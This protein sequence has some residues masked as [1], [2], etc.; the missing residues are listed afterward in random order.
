MSDKLKTLS[1]AQKKVIVGIACY[2]EAQ[3]KGGRFRSDDP[4]MDI[5]VKECFD[6]SW[7]GNWDSNY[8]HQYLGQAATYAAHNE[9]ECLRIASELDNE[10][11]FAFKSMMIDIIGDNAMMMLHAA[12]IY[13]E[14]GMPVFT[15]PEEKEVPREERNTQEDDGTYVLEDCYRRLADVGAVR[16]ENDKVFTMV[17]E[18]RGTR[19]SVGA[20]YDYWLNHGI[21]PV[22]GLVG[23][24]NPRQSVDTPEGRLYYLVCTGNLV[25]PVLEWGLEKIDEWEYRDKVQN[26]RMLSWDRSGELCRELRAR[27]KPSAPQGIENK[28]NAPQDD[29]QVVRWTAT[30]QQ[31]IEGG[32]VFPSNYIERFIKLTYSKRGS[33]LELEVVGVMKPRTAKIKSDDGRVLTYVDTMRPFAYYEVET[34]PEHNSIVR[35]S[36]F[37]KNENFED[38]E[39]RYTVDRH[40][41]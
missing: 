11:K 39:Y 18:D 20:N 23:Y 1:A 28:V 40:N 25:I 17:D 4:E 19:D 14:I 27:K 31:R 41:D 13:K 15:K 10:A 26:D 24:V 9:K 38:L 36:I 35:V 30:V 29:R 6:E 34:E 16:G 21:C 3:G 2:I 12:Y 33:M 22:S 32:R 7:V 37:Q 5:I 8:R